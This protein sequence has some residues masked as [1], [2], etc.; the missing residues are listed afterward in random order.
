MPLVR[1]L[2]RTFFWEFMVAQNLGSGRHQA[3]CYTTFVAIHGAH[4]II[5]CGLPPLRRE[6]RSHLLAFCHCGAGFPFGVIVR[7]LVLQSAD[8]FGV[9]VHPRLGVWWQC[10]VVE[11]SAG[12]VG[13]HGL[14]GALVGRH[15]DVAAIVLDIEYIVATFCYSVGGLCGASWGGCRFKSLSLQELQGCGQSLLLR[16]VLCH[17]AHTDQPCK[18]PKS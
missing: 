14:L 11:V 17:C 16:D 9:A 6:E 1:L 15:D 5:W 7:R 8:A 18:G 4:V 2:S 3:T 13:Q 10:V 12:G